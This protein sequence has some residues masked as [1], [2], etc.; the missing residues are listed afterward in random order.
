[1]RDSVPRG[2]FRILLEAGQRERALTFARERGWLRQ[3][4]EYCGQHTVPIDR[5][6]SA[7]LALLAQPDHA[8]CAMDVA[9]SVADEG[10][11][12]LARMI[13]LDRIEH[14]QDR[15]ARRHAQDFLRYRLPGHDVPRVAEGL[16]AAGWRLQHVHDAPDD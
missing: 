12:R 10:G 13:V 8:D 11:A 6:T 16:N 1:S 14:A 15:E 5:E 4:V 9:A 7:L 2:A 3:D